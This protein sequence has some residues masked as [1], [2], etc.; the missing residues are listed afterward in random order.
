ALEDVLRWGVALCGVLEYLAA[1]RPSPIVHH[2]IKPANLVL[3]SASGGIFLV[4]FGAA[5]APH[6]PADGDTWPQSRPHGTRAYAAPEQYRALSEPRSDIYALAATLYP[7]ATDDDPAAHPFSFP[8]L[9]A[10]GEL[11]LVLGA[12]LDPDV[13]RRPTAATLCR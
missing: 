7:L 8:Q 6:I 11:G 1:R 13:S 12:A 2:D 10:L 5:A 4:D 9:G 3:D